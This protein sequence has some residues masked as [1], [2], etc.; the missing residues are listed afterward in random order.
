MPFKKLTKQFVNITNDN[1]FLASTLPPGNKNTPNVTSQGLDVCVNVVTGVAR[2]IF[3]SY[4]N[5]LGLPH[6]P[7]LPTP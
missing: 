4:A 7:G 2:F 6:V 1:D 5:F 3:Q